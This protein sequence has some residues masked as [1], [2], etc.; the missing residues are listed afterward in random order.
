MQYPIYVVADKHTRGL[1]IFWNSKDKYFYDTSNF[2]NIHYFHIKITEVKIWLSLDN[3]ILLSLD[4]VQSNE[5]FVFSFSFWH[6][7]LQ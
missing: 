2:N 1:N 3:Q 5:Q 6:A 4:W 7:I